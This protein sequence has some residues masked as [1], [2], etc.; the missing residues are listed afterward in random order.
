MLRDIVSAEDRAA[1]EKF[2]KTVKLGVAGAIALVLLIVLAIGFFKR[3]A[4]PKAEF[5][6][7]SYDDVARLVGP[8]AKTPAAKKEELWKSRFE[9]KS[10]LW[11]GRVT[12]VQSAGVFGDGVL[13][14]RQHDGP[15]A[16]EVKLTLAKSE[17]EKYD[18]SVGSKVTYRGRFASYGGSPGIVLDGGKIDSAKE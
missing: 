10:V 6:K 11:T 8:A 15:G 9:G 17:L 16:A 18:L 3:P 13:L 12:E 2:Q 1:E 5:A 14:I 4:A 7:V